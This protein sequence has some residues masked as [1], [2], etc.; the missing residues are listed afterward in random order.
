MFLNRPL[1]QQVRILITIGVGSKGKFYE[2]LKSRKRK[3]RE[4]ESDRAEKYKSLAQRFEAQNAL[5]IQKIRDLEVELESYRQEHVS[6]LRD[7]EKIEILHSQGIVD[8]D[9]N[10]IVERDENEMS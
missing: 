4:I 10:L 9:G 8:S 5:K 6:S 2:M 7:R 1:E 3:H